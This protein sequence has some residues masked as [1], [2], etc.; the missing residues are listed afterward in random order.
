MFQWFLPMVAPS[1]PSDEKTHLRF[2]T[3]ETP[4]NRSSSRATPGFKWLEVAGT[5]P[6][7]MSIPFWVVSLGLGKKH[8]VGS[9]G[10]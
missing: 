5:D 8:V 3:T 2:H 4:K 1:G 9:V 6:E 7:K 10:K